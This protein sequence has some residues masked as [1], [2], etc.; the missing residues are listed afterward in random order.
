MTASK[1]SLLNISAQNIF[2][3]VDYMNDLPAASSFNSRTIMQL[4]ASLYRCSTLIA[5]ALQ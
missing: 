4:E 3:Y 5:D 2:F 1:I